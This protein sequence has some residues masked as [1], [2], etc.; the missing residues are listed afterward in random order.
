MRVLP[1][2]LGQDRA[3][4]RVPAAAPNGHQGAPHPAACSPSEAGCQ[5]SGGDCSAACRGEEG[6]ER[7]PGRTNHIPARS[8]MGE[9]GSCLE[10]DVSDHPGWGWGL[11]ASLGGG[12]EGW[13]LGHSWLFLFPGLCSGS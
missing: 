13:L 10:L 7:A 8:A 4:S 6:P 5:G 1:F 9:Q 12:G 3:P 2:S 11:I